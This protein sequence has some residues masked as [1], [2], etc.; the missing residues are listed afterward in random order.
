MLFPP[1]QRPGHPSAQAAA[2]PVAEAAGLALAALGVRTVFAVASD[3]CLL[4]PALTAC[5]LDV[6]DVC[7]PGA[8]TIMAEAH[9]GTGG[10][11]AVLAVPLGSALV[12]AIPGLAHAARS[13]TPLLV[14]A[15]EASDGLGVARQAALLTAAGALIEPVAD[16]AETVS[17]IAW[18]LHTTRIQRRPLVLTFGRQ[19]LE[20]SCPRPPDDLLASVGDLNTP[21]PPPPDAGTISSLAGLLTTA[22]RLVFVAGRGARDAGRELKELAERTGALLATSASAHGLFADDGWDLG[23]VGDWSAPAVAEL[24]RDADVLIGW[25]CSMREWRTRRGDLVGPG[26][27]VVQVG[28]DPVV[29]AGV[30]VGVAGDAAATARALLRQLTG[31]RTGYR[32]DE[33]RRRL[34]DLGDGRDAG[35][36]PVHVEGRID[37][38]TLA[39]LLDAV[40]PQERT[41]VVDRGDFLRYPI[42]LMRVPDACGFWCSQL[43]EEPGLAPAAG[44]GA[45][46]A[47]PERLAVAVLS[48]RGV[49]RA[50]ADLETAVRLGLPLLIVVYNTGDDR[51]S[52]SV[53]LAAVAAGYGC[54]ASVVRQGRD[55]KAV[56]DWLA[57]PRDGPLLIDARIASVRSGS[58]PEEA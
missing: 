22:S 15:A 52:G 44:I 58:V 1:E 56:G 6:I 26:A 46:L 25:G 27:R 9:T 13:R 3:E 48:D 10:E 50:A 45:A 39:Y 14:L 16:P 23:V 36:Q 47:R 5:G 42:S 28:L 11:P 12:S 4:T 32:T 43:I 17:V 30:D 2:V 53:D 40:L 31:T 49:L 55:L 41:L 20:A 38:W 8:A 54:A 57:G 21:E 35:Y 18:A 51:L 37:P 19:V 24:V 34:A 29:G 7:R 33:V